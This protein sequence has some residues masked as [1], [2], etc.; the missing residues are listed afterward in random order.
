MMYIPDVP[1]TNDEFIITS[2]RNIISRKCNIQKPSALEIPSGRCFI[3]HGVT[4]RAD[5]APIQVQKYSFVEEDTVLQPCSTAGEN[6]RP[7]PLTIGS[8]CLIGKRCTIEAAVIG[9]GC[10]VGDDCQLSPRCILKDFV[11]VVKGAV[12]PQD[13]VC[14]PFSII[15]GSPGRIVGDIPEGAATMIPNSRVDRYRALRVVKQESSTAKSKSKVAVTATKAAATDTATA[16]TADTA[17][18]TATTTP[19]GAT[20]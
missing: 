17:A 12:V 7:I 20:T 19:A 16:T 5:L 2:T 9:M 10:T 4:I 1:I 13:M 6:A 3:G 18:A 8:H 14:P 11:K 15:A